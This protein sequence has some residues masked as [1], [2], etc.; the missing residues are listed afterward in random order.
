MILKT[1][2]IINEVT[3]LSDARYCAGMGVD[4][5]GF[6][7]DESHD[8]YVDL[9]N[10]NEITGWVAGIKLIAES[11]QT[12]NQQTVPYNVDMLLL[13]NID[14]LPKYIG[15]SAL[16]SVDIDKIPAY[17]QMLE[18][19]SSKVSGIVLTSEQSQ[20]TETHKAEIKTI[21][22]RLGLD[23]Y[24]SFG[25]TNDNVLELINELPIKGLSIS[26]SDEIRP[27]YK[28]YDKLADILEQLEEDD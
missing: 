22:A 10:Y 4:Y 6:R 23:I 13:D 17:E 27:G 24:L 2:V 18:E 1:T 12:V 25:V 28:D 3:N 9:A 20:I 16:W 21:A 5:I 11:S 8:K 14:L 19:H 15:Q 7:I 26:G